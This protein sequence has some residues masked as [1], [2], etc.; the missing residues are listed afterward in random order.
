M[1]D[2]ITPLKIAPKMGEVIQVIQNEIKTKSYED[3]ITYTI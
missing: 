2:P 1:H 3:P